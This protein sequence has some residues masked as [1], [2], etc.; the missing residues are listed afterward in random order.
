MKVSER[1]E[2]VLVTAWT[3][4]LLL[5]VAGPARESPDGLEMLA[6][7]Q[8]WRGVGAVLDPGYWPPLWP[9][10]MVPFT[11]GDGV[12]AARLANLI[13]AGLVAMP[14]H[15]MAWRLAGPWSARAVVALWALSPAVLEHAE[16]LD[17]RPLTWLLVAGAVGLAVRDR[18]GWAFALASLAPLARAEGLV[19][20][21]ALA[22]AALLL[23]RW[24]WAG[25]GV[26]ALTPKALWGVLGPKPL[27]WSHLAQTWYGTWPIEDLVALHGAASVPTGYRLWVLDALDRGVDRHAVHLTGMFAEAPEAVPF[28]ARGLV[29]STGLATMVL[30]MM[31]GALL[32][33]RGWRAAAL[34]SLGLAPLVAITLVPAARGQASTAANLMFLL[35]LG[36]VLVAVALTAARTR[37]GAPGPSVLLVAAV[38]ALEAIWGPMRGPAPDFTEDSL[39]ARQLGVWLARHPPPTGQVASTLGSRSIVL[40]AGL[41]GVAL[42]T[43][44]EAWSPPA[45]SGAVVTNADLV[46]ES[47]GRGLAL[48][49]DPEWALEAVTIEPA[50]QPWYAYLERR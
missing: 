39:A 11:G 25:L 47:G 9:A 17:A 33:V 41:E 21:V 31:G 34:L 24:R 32:A 49:E 46:S 20:P 3:L 6:L 28:M 30:V 26:L 5:S 50:G 44:W 40:R 1:E 43:V 37:L 14:L 23:G 42:P 36:L 38:C 45:G 35:P 48:L 22:A 13:V 18:W 10:L 2:R 8:S 12:G 19:V 4:I 16:V 27:A 15:A 29:E 7:A